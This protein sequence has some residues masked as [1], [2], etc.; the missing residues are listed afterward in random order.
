MANGSAADA[1]DVSD[2]P[3]STPDKASI[4]TAPV[5]SDNKDTAADSI[6]ADVSQTAPTD[7]AMVSTDTLASP[8]PDPSA[9]AG[10]TDSAK[11]AHTDVEQ[12]DTPVSMGVDADKTVSEPAASP[13][14]PEEAVEAAAE[15]AVE[16]AADDIITAEGTEAPVKPAVS[17]QG[18]EEIVLSQEGDGEPSIAAEPKEEVQAEQ[19][20]PAKEE[21]QADAAEQVKQEPEANTAEASMAAAEPETKAKAKDENTETEQKA[22]TSQ[23][24]DTVHKD[25]SPAGPVSNAKDTAEPESR[26][27]KRPAPAV[28]R[29]AKHARTNQAA[30][31]SWRGQSCVVRLSQR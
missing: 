17:Q 4:S 14:A 6:M 19:A 26:G 23:K 22:E 30:G 9:A 16:A 20:D 2:G 7:G 13:A 27:V 8:K 12:E 24:A 5:N 11:Q 15:E 21:E 3:H 29:G 28:T 25:N 1:P 31:V 18:T 10:V